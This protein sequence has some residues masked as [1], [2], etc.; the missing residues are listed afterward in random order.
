MKATFSVPDEL[1]RKVK[2]RSALE[3]R[4]VRDVVITL[5][6]HWLGQ[7]RNVPQEETDWSHFEAPLRHLKKPEITDHSM[8][9]IRASIGKRFDETV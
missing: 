7:N 3:G 4:P 1:Y 2:A 9:A 6:Q 8:E 5:F